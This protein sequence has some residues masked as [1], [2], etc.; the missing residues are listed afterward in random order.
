MDP[1]R[2][3]DRTREHAERVRVA[4]LRL[5]RERQLVQRGVLVVPEPCEQRAQAGALEPLPLL[6]RLTLELRLE[7]RAMS[8]GGS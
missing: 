6:D 8:I 2:L 4:E 7:H 1:Y 5:H 3:L